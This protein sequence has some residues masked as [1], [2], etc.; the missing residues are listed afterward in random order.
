MAKPFLKTRRL[1]LYKTELPHLPFYKSLYKN[2]EVMKHLGGPIEDAEIERQ[3]AK[4]IERWKAEGVGGIVVALQGTDTLIG[5]G[6]LGKTG[7]T[8]KDDLEVGYI[9]APSFKG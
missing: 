4:R 5:V 9:I 7:F 6:G 2:D 3:V 8:G 1:D